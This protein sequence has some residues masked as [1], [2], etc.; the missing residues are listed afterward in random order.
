MVQSEALATF[1]IVNGLRRVSVIT[2]S[3][4]IGAA[5]VG[6]AGR[7]A[8]KNSGLAGVG[9]APEGTTQVDL[10]ELVGI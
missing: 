3:H 1:S 4:I 9:E 6:K 7:F 5:V 10:S 2:A 8:D